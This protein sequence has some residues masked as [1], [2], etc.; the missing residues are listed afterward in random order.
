MNFCLGNGSAYLRRLKQDREFR[1]LSSNINTKSG[2]AAGLA[3]EG[4][5][6]LKEGAGAVFS[7]IVTTSR[8][9]ENNKDCTPLAVRCHKPEQETMT[10]YRS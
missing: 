6:V 4:S 5:I 10:R 2:R 1:E 7:R 9:Q 8:S 3:Q